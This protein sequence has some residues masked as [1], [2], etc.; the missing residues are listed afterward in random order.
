[1]IGCKTYSIYVITSPSGLQY[2]GLDKNGSD[3]V[4][5]RDHIKRRNSKKF[6]YPIRNAIAKYG[7][8]NMKFE[9]TED[10]L[11]R[12]EAQ[13]RECFWI[14]ELNTM[15]P[16]G[17]NLT[18]GGEVSKTYC[19][20]VTQKIS[21]SRTGFKMAEETKQKIAKTLKGRVFSDEHRVRLSKALTGYKR[22]DE[23]RKN[24]SLIKKGKPNFKNRGRVVSE[25]TKR[26]IGQLNKGR[27]WTQELKEKVLAARK[28]AG[29]KNTPETLLKMSISAKKRWRKK[30]WN[31]LK[32]VVIF[33]T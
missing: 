11:T 33:P 17:Y 7:K 12:E 2:V 3:R 13:V 20:E 15:K 14:K 28:L 8:E 9:I 23:E 19:D 10:G 32:T 4:R 5:F 1:M 18:S 26:K 30:K 25:E 6:N 16:N 22:S 31:E 24:M 29:R 27:R 21:K